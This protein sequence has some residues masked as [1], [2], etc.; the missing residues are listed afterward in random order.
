MGSTWSSY[1]NKIINQD[2]SY[3]GLTMC[4]ITMQFHPRQLSHVSLTVCMQS[5]SPSVVSGWRWFLPSSRPQLPQGH[6]ETNKHLHSHFPTAQSCSTWSVKQQHAVA[7][8]AALCSHCVSD[9]GKLSFEEFN[10]Y[11]ADGVLTTEELQE[12]FYSIDGQQNKWV[13][14]VFFSDAQQCCFRHFFI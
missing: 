10:T 1:Q 4:T 8:T 7:W 12:L 14:T 3:T 6:M 13:G 11:F 5:F 2:N 9:D